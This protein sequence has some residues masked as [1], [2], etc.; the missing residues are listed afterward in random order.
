MGTYDSFFAKA[1]CPRCGKVEDFE[2]QS[3][4]FGCQSNDYNI[5]DEV[6]IEGFPIAGTHR[7]SGISDCW[8]K[9]CQS[10]SEKGYCFFWADIIIKDGKFV[11]IE[12]V[13]TE[14]F[15]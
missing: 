9:E 15:E 11:G 10:L 4:D 7:R 3:K 14:E 6:F 12:N 8:S 5:G 1:K 13:R 2:F